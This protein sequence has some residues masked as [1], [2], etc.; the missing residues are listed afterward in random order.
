[1]YASVLESVL[2]YQKEPKHSTYEQS[3][4]IK[5]GE[6]IN[7]ARI[8]YGVDVNDGIRIINQYGFDVRGLQE[9]I[10]IEQLTWILFGFDHRAQVVRIYFERP[11]RDDGPTGACNEYIY[12]NGKFSIFGDTKVYYWTFEMPFTS[13][14][15]DV[16]ELMKYSRYNL[17]AYKKS[18][19]KHKWYAYYINH[20]N[21]SVAENTEYLLNI[22]KSMCNT[23]MYNELVHLLTHPE[24]KNKMVTWISFGDGSLNIYMRE[25]HVCKK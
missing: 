22:A 23:N 9:L 7:C 16:N 12:T 18:G 6:S 19:N 15:P 13:D 21:R 14:S 1:M 2:K 20:G 8:S 17:V 3:I 25:K 11:Q 5:S 4:K 10:P 24:V